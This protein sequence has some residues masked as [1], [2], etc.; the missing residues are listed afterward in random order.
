MLGVVVRTISVWFLVCAFEPL[1]TTE[2]HLSGYYEN[3]F[4]AE[5]TRD[6]KEALLDASKLRLDFS[7]GGGEDELE[8][9]GNINVIAF[10]VPIAINIRRYLP[11]SAVEE[12]TAVGISDINETFGLGVSHD[13]VFLDNA[14]LSWQNGA[15][16]IRAGKQ[17]LS[18]GSGYSYNPTDLFH[19]KDMLD[20]TYEKEGVAG[21]RLDRQ[22]GVGNELTAIWVINNNFETSGFAA[23]MATHLAAGYDVAVSVHQIEDTTSVVL[24]S[25]SS[26]RQQ[27]RALGLELSGSLLGLGLWA[28]GNYNHM[29]VEDGFVRVIAGLDYTFA[30]G[31]YVMTE[32]LFN[33]RGETAPPY[34]LEDWL[35]G[36]AFGEPVGRSMILTGLKHD[37]SALVSGSLYCFSGLDGGFMINPRV[38]WSIAQNADVTVFGAATLGDN[39]SQFPSGLV[40]L[41]ARATVYF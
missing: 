12:L 38:D 28:E 37:L 21:V 41:V 2:L 13:R 26:H 10:H 3:A 9:Q 31:L 6:E 29:E 18:W 40:S 4:Q 33:G 36:I 39:D 17:Q 20:P 14:F 34:P 15:Y 35:A 22:W 24:D 5:Y 1:G 30:G 16:R 7:A 8:F 27:R 19:Q 32:G 11:D 23:R 25:R